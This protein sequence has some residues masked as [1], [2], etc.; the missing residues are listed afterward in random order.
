MAESI[1]KT[2]D[3]QFQKGSKFRKGYRFKKGHRFNKGTDY[4]RKAGGTKVSAGG[5]MFGKFIGKKAR[6]VSDLAG[7]PG[8]TSVD[9]FPT[10][11]KHTEDQMGVEAYQRALETGDKRRLAGIRTSGIIVHAER[12]STSW[13]GDQDLSG[14]MVGDVDQLARVAYDRL[15]DADTNSAYVVYMNQNKIV[16]QVALPKG[17]PK[18]APID[19]VSLQDSV[20]QY[21]NKAAAPEDIDGYY[22]IQNYP[23][24][25]MD[26][27]D[28]GIHG[29]IAK[30][31]DGYLGGIVL[32]SGF[33]YGLVQVN[34]NDQVQI[35]KRQIPFSTPD[36][37]SVT[38]YNGPYI[39]LDNHQ[40][41]LGEPTIDE[42]KP[43][44]M[45][46]HNISR[47]SQTIERARDTTLLVYSDDSK[48]A[49]IQEIPNK[50]FKKTR[51]FNAFV[52]KQMEKYGADE[53]IAVVNEKKLAGARAT[54]D[55]TVKNDIDMKIAKMN[56][57]TM[58]TEVLDKTLI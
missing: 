19:T 20:I 29:A 39:V 23:D 46:N 37:K 2:N 32:S 26:N 25:K 50:L 55:S 30:N 45:S 3:T 5:R 44:K 47:I 54:V 9:D 35:Q 34:N 48:A 15:V 13:R 17:Y 36:D 18:T 31:F 51:K 57:I 1:Y 8:I 14:K 12:P 10:T 6:G 52:K 28:I 7:N 11:D 43:L 27:N 49:A 42:S 16:S 58:S 38:G 56:G 40:E 41:L 22:I 4:T 21:L 33:Q 24:A 53:V